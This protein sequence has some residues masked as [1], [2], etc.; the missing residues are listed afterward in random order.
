MTKRNRLDGRIRRT[1]S[2]HKVFLVL[3]CSIAAVSIIRS[4]SAAEHVWSERDFE[5]EMA[6]LRAEPKVGLAFDYALSS[7]KAS[8]TEL[9]ELTEIPAPPFMESARAAHFSKLLAEIGLD[10]VIDDVGNVIGRRHG[11][12]GDRTIGY[13][14]HLDTVFPEGT[15]V[16]VKFRNGKLYA[17]G[18]GDN[19]RGL[20]TVLMVARAL[21][22]AN[23]TTLADVVFIGNVGEEGLGDLRGMKHLFRDGAMPIDSLIAID[24]GNAERIV[25]GGVGSHRYRV[26]FNGAGGH[27]WGAF[28]IANPHH[29]LGVAI[30][31]FVEEAVIATSTGAKSSYN[32]GRVGGGVSINS[33]PYQSWMEV[34][35]RS[36]EQSKLDEI[37]AI[38]QRSMKIAVKQINAERSL[39]RAINMEIQAVGKRPAVAGNAGSRL[40]QRALAATES[41]GLKPSLV[42][43]STD[44]NTPLSK[45]IPAV[46]MSRGGRSG[47]AHSL[48]EWWQEEQSYISVQIGIL[49][50]L[51]EAGLSE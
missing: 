29:A 11:S 3:L 12:S 37:D 18:V 16:K 38:F 6:S 25:Y 24:G 48:D 44:A 42:L 8:V 1:Y 7:Y 22:Y 9:V 5:Q 49:T 40:V 32:V 27:S 45:G 17:P 30:A 14:A 13:S 41:F 2:G 51:A 43:S 50:L 4:I 19:S 36:T 33:I 21:N 47:R 34:D 39:G 35:M 10:V 46:T 26:T 15:D 23:I 31:K 28:G 20:V